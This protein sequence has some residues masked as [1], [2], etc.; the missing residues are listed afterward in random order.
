MT[1]KRPHW[2]RALGR[3]FGRVLAGAFVAL[4]LGGAVLAVWVQ[5]TLSPERLRPQIVAQLER[6]FQRRVDIEGV[7]VALHQGVRVT[8]LK[9]HA[10]PGAPEPFF[11]SA[12]LMIVRY[13]L[14]ALLQG[15]FVLTLVR[16]VNPRV[17][18]YRRPDGSWNLS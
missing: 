11:L 3:F 2:S 14:P 6:T 10:R 18:L 5:R 17:A 9:V 8:G 16:L 12:D 15:R 4:V 1:H 13:S 7:G